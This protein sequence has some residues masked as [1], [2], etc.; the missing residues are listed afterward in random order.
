MLHLLVLAIAPGIFLLMFF[1]LKDRYEKES[2][3]LVGKVFLAG[4]IAV[5]PA[6]ILED[7]LLS[8]LSPRMADLPALIYSSYLGI[9][10][11]EELVKF[12]AVMLVA[13]NSKEFN[14]P[15]DGVVY[16]VASSLGFA[17]LEN[18]FYVL[19]GGV[20]VGIARAVLAV[21]SHALDGAVM[22]VYLGRAKLMG[23]R[24]GLTRA[25]IYPV[26]LHGTYD[27]LLFVDP[28]AFLF[29]GIPLMLLALK[30]VLRSMRMLED[31]SPFK[32]PRISP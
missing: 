6:V 2:L 17:T 18:I 15:F 31:S 27:F 10:F 3:S 30:F 21:P 24:G 16:S 22:G 19:E 29:L 1:Y 7:F 14:E 23:Y 32:P 5:F 4:I 11:P 12:L 13:Y 20:L 25:L 9:G 28:I 8:D 26:L